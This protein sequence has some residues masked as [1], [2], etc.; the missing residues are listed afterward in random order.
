MLIFGYG[1][2]TPSMVGLIPWLVS[3]LICTRKCGE[4]VLI[5]TPFELFTRKLY[6]KLITLNMSKRSISAGK[7]K[8]GICPSC[9]FDVT[10]A[11]ESYRFSLLT[12]FVI[13]KIYICI[14]PFARRY[15]VRCIL[16]LLRCQDIATVVFLHLGWF[17]T[18]QVYALL[19]LRELT[20][21]IGIK[22]LAQGH[23]HAGCIRAPTHNIDGLVIMSP[24]HV[25]KTTRAPFVWLQNVWYPN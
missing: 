1:C 9:H 18:D 4:I 17:A 15:K 19:A 5:M 12:N 3:C 22:Y 13:I 21:D 20:K 14:A 6:F 7:L 16:L 23:R 10:H 25:N 8:G 11:G 2:C 24:A